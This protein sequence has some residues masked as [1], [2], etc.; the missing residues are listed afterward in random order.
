MDYDG[1]KKMLIYQ[2]FIG[3][4]KRDGIRLICFAA[5]ILVMVFLLKD[6]GSGLIIISLFLSG[7]LMAAG[8]VSLKRACKVPDK[9]FT[10]TVTD[11]IKI[12]KNTGR[13]VHEGNKDFDRSK[14]RIK[15]IFKI[16]DDISGDTVEAERIENWM[17]ETSDIRND[18]IET[19]DPVIAFRFGKKYY[20][21]LPEPEEEIDDGSSDDVDE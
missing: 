15:W 6:S 8:A 7:G 2:K 16:Q 4:K 20:M 17:S 21:I 18:M 5:L 10:G 1:L 9:I 14:H 11:I 12:S 3:K 13:E 19:G